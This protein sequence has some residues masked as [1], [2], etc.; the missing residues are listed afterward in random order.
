MSGNSRLARSMAAAAA[1]VSGAA[2]VRADVVIAENGQPR[3]VVVVASDA[4]APEKHAAAELATIL[5]QATGA[6]FEVT[7]KPKAG[8]ARLLVCYGT[9]FILP[10]YHHFLA[11]RIS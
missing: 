8:A 6:T 4:T 10:F 9:V 2:G 11:L 1:V 5:K 3:A 7:G